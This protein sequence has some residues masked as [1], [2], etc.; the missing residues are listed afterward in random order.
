M[1][2]YEAKALAVNLE[3]TYFPAAKHDSRS[4]R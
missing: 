1:G 2:H 3:A 4:P